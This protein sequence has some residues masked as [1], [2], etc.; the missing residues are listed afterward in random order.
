L[1]DQLL[2]WLEQ[3]HNVDK[4]RKYHNWHHV[5]RLYTWADK[6]GFKYDLVLDIAIAFHDAVYDHLPNK[7]LRSAEL[8][9]EI[10]P[11][12]LPNIEQSVLDQAYQL[13]LTTEDH[14]PTKDNRLILCD[15]ADF[16]VEFFRKINEQNVLLECHA[17]YGITKVE[18]YRNNI[19][20]VRAL[21]N[22]I[23]D[24]DEMWGD[25]TPKFADILKG[26]GDHIADAQKTYAGICK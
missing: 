13:V 7:E 26:L 14:T 6:W 25:D 20:F 10:V 2:D 21:R 19:T 16:S 22:R 12:F 24:G 9:H 3:F 11:R 4:A 18:F 8:I 5:N 1:P 15:L 17:V 23:E